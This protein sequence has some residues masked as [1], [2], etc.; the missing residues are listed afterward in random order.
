EFVHVTWTAPTESDLTGYT[1]QHFFST[2]CLTDNCAPGQGTQLWAPAGGAAATAT[3]GNA[4]VNKGGLTRIRMKACYFSGGVGFCSLPVE[5]N[6]STRVIVPPMTVSAPSVDRNGTFTVS[7]DQVESS[8]S[9]VLQEKIGSGSWTNISL[10]NN[11]AL[12][13]VITGKTHGQ[14]LKYRV[15][16]CYNSSCSANFR[17]SNTVSIDFSP[18]APNSISATVIDGN[19]VAV[20][21]A[22]AGTVDSYTV[23]EANSLAFNPV[24]GSASPT[25]CISWESPEGIPICNG[26][27][28]DNAH[29][30]NDRSNGTYYYRVKACNTYGC[31]PWKV[32][33]AAVVGYTPAI[34]P[35]INVP[36][37]SNGNVDVSWGITSPV[38]SQTLY[39]LQ[40]SE[41]S[42][43]SEV[44]QVY[45]GANTSKTISAGNNV[46]LY[47]RVRACDGGICS[48]WKTAT[49][50]VWVLRLPGEPESLTVPSTDGNGIY[51]VSWGPPA[52]IYPGTTYQLWESA[53]SDFANPAKVYEADVPTQVIPFSLGGTFY[54]VTKLEGDST[55]ITKTEN[56]TFYYRIRACNLGVNWACSEH[57][58]ASDAISLNIAGFPPSAP[59]W[60]STNDSGVNENQNYIISWGASTVFP[61][62]S[63]YELSRKIN[64]GAWST[65][66]TGTATSRTYSGS[67]TEGTYKYRVRACKSGNC[68]SWRGTATVLIVHIG[69]GG[70][71]GGGTPQSVNPGGME[72]LESAPANN[73]D[74]GT[75]G[76]AAVIHEEL[77]NDVAYKPALVKVSI[78]DS[79]GYSI[80]PPARPADIAR[81]HYAARP[82]DSV[83]RHTMR[84]NAGKANTRFDEAGHAAPLP[85]M[86]LRDDPRIMRSFAERGGVSPAKAHKTGIGGPDGTYAH[87][88]RHVYDTYGNL[89]EVRELFSNGTTGDVYWMG[90]EADAAGN[91]T[92]E[93][94]GKDTLTGGGLSAGLTTIRGYDQATGFL[95]GVTTGVNTNTD[96]QNMTFDWDLAGNLTKR[97]DVNADSGNGI[98]ESFAYDALYRLRSVIF[99]PLAVGANAVTTYM[100]Y[101][102]VGNIKYKDAD[103]A[104]GTA[105]GFRSYVYGDANHKHAVTAVTAGADS[106]TYTYDANGNMLSA[107]IGGVARN[108]T[109]TA[110][111]K[112]KTIT[113]GNVSS[114]FF[115][116]HNRARYKQVETDNASVTTTLYIGSLYEKVDKP[117]GATEHRHF[118]YAAGRAVLVHKRDYTGTTL[119]NAVNEYLHRDHLGSVVAVTSVD[120]STGAVTIIDQMSFGAW[121]KR[122]NGISW[123]ASAM[124]VFTSPSNFSTPRGYT[125][126]EHMDK[127]GLINMNGRIYD[128]EIGRFLSADPFVQFPESTQGYNRYTYV[129]N[130]PLS[131]TDP[132]GFAIGGVLGKM[133]GTFLVTVAPF[134]APVCTIG[135]SVAAA[136]IGG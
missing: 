74:T 22:E 38:S 126:H 20:G 48:A 4:I 97:K 128:P 2:E 9:Y 66:Y 46:H 101:D 47:Y 95:R 69:G 76:T 134:L 103:N 70:G 110:F 80:M 71:G 94:I 3:S 135:C 18:S 117:G 19:D 107:T 50:D 116:D 26:W 109:W 39:Q 57:G 10:P 59:P 119:N 131:Y 13:H 72:L 90:E 77:R 40:Q 32:S 124:G 61:S 99:D 132:S 121:G 64:S 84:Q 98:E 115:Y 62:G 79:S 105:G 7:W 60:I 78:K 67:A 49:N 85:L 36:A 52:S 54:F 8:T 45:E 81:A 125:G 1:F 129:G 55:T 113:K 23:Q 63:V 15:R 51:V 83:I 12:S 102:A 114:E 92:K 91:F 68:S 130:N 35:F 33:G 41:F 53:T 29:H 106:R 86:P 28:P 43:F 44:A 96:I 89:V 65:I 14:Q 136:A 34:P 111:N 24:T 133:L 56:G 104:T 27:G 82:Q 6:Q 120:R 5:A 17:E 123:A 108:V 58:D 75:G 87:A 100:D 31:S 122:R 25:K 118:I 37:T 16:A 112:A 88:V 30:F 127:L 42:N 21:W 73:T 93:V 11:T